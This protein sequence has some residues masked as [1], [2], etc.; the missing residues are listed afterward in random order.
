MAR[1]YREDDV[2]VRPRRSGALRL[3]AL[4]V[5]LVVIAAVVVAVILVT[6]TSDDAKK[7]VAV[8]ACNADP[9]GG[10]PTASGTVANS[11]SKTSN[12]VIRLRFNDSQGNSVSEG[13]APVKDVE[14]GQTA[15]WQLTGARSTD[16]PVTCELR[17]VSRTHLPGQ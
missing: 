11:S 4:L 13:A 6:R 1:T 16:G 2:E 9:G 15:R 7:D 5:A 10:K 14:S 3:I 17:S 12:Y 8:S